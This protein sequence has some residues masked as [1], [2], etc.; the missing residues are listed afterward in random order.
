[1]GEGGPV[2]G[3]GRLPV[4]AGDFGVRQGDRGVRRQAA[5]RGPGG[6]PG[7]P[8]VGRVLRAGHGPGPAGPGG[9][10]R[11]CRRRG[12]GRGRRPAAELRPGPPGEAAGG[13]QGRPAVFPAGELPERGEKGGGGPG[14]VPGGQPGA[15]QGRAGPGGAPGAGPGGADFGFFQAVPGEEAGQELLGLQRPGTRG[16]GP[17]LP[18]GRQPHGPGPGGVRP[19]RGDHD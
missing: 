12:L 10:G 2:R 19:V 7:G 6:G 18:G 16:G 1:M 9:L 14:P 3:G 11:G 8:G 13:A 4:G 5:H 15:G 17:V